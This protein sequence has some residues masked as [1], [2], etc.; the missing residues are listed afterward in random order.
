MTM[1]LAIAQGEHV[2]QSEADLRRL[3]PG[4]VHLIQRKVLSRLDGHCEKFISLSPLVF[5]STSSRDGR[6]DVSPRGDAPGF[7]LVLDDRHIVLP[8]RPG[9]NRIDTLRN[10][11]ENGYAGLIFLIPG[12]EETLRVNGSAVVSYA[13]DL[14]TRMQ[15]KRSLPRSAIVV[16]V[17]E[18]FLHCGRAFRRG[19]IWDPAHFPPAQALPPFATMLADHTRPD[20]TEQALIDQSTNAPLY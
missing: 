19:A 17:E 12:R 20:S 11:V 9:N 1:N 16:A 3:Y 10:I 6:C 13:A 8:D 2:A 7:V 4:P 14:L 18:A 15:M 5:V